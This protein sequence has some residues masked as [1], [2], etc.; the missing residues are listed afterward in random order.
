M[1]TQPEK[2][3]II[4]V[5]AGLSGLGTAISCSLA[6]HEVVVLEA[7]PEIAEVGAGLQ[8]TPNATR[9]LQ[10]WNVSKS[11]WAK[12][13][14]PTSLSVHRYTGELL[15]HEES[16]D[17]K[18]RQ[19]YGAPFTDMHRADLQI[20]LLDRAKE[21]GT[22]FFLGEKVETID[23]AKPS[24]KTSSGKT[25]TGDL[26]VASD[27]LW[28][29]CR[30]LMLGKKD[31]PLPTGDLA[32]RIVL[33]LD[34]IQDTDL[35]EWVAKPTVHFWIGPNTHAV[36]Y[37]MRD[38]KMYNIVLL[39]PDTLPDGL[40]KQAGSVDEIRTLFKGWDPILTRFLNH[41]KKGVDKWKLMHLEQMPHWVN[42]ES[43]LVFM[44]DACHPM[45]P[46]LAQGA[47]SSLEDAAVLGGLLAKLTNKRQ[48][49]RV[50]RLY[51]RLRKERGEAIVRETF[52]QRRDFHRVDGPEQE[53]RDRQFKSKLGKDLGTDAFPSRWTCPQ[54][55][56][57]LYGYDAIKEVED[58][59][60]KNPLFDDGTKL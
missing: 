34:E 49:P 5:G 44:G 35:R 51:E 11:F 3:K 39:C 21:L 31:E 19:R 38:G 28:S 4:I 40:A 17:L 12:G 60:R 55:Q 20:A 33:S 2:L 41:V 48:L 46:Y 54:V 59:V 13:A 56:P 9:L 47:N 42:D 30:E 15:A 6:G 22:Q 16:Y 26:I 18:M 7:A 8:M 10:H 14:E 36:G 24:V 52:N 53:A 25:Y 23:F 37:S 1:A 50:L 58:A 32:Y 29:R 27:G 45:L 43:N 57:W